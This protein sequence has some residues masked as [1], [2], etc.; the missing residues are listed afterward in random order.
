MAGEPLKTGQLDPASFK[1]NL[2]IVVSDPDIPEGPG[3]QSLRIDAGDIRPKTIEWD[4]ATSAIIPSSA[5]A[6]DFLNLTSVGTAHGHDWEVGDLAFVVNP[7]TPVLVRIPFASGG[8]RPTAITWDVD[9]DPTI[10]VDAVTGD[11]LVAI[12]TGEAHGCVWELDDVA[13]IVDKDTNALVQIKKITQLRPK[14]YVWDVAAD[15]TIPAAAINGDFLVAST[16]GTAHDYDWEINDLAFV[17]DAS[18]PV[19]QRIPKSAFTSGIATYVTSADSPV[20]AV[21]G[22]VYFIDTSTGSVEMFLPATPTGKGSIAFI[23][24]A[25]TYATN[26]LIIRRNGNPI[27]ADNT[28]DYQVA[29]NDISFEMQYAGSTYGWGVTAAR[30]AT[31]IQNAT[32][33]ASDLIEIRY[34][35]STSVTMLMGDREKLVATTSNVDGDIFLPDSTPLQPGWQATV[36]QIGDGQFTFNPA[37]GSSDVIISLSNQLVTIGKGVQ[38]S[39][40]LVQPGTWLIGGGLTVG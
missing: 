19:L 9:A 35:A 2:Q 13:Y 12:S 21:E 20:N 14:T 18:T 15:P 1:A 37:A 25:S 16:A 8:M 6:G 11:F 30:A 3:K 5:I 23:P 27:A 36:A 39:V 17:V 24:V 33:N 28:D 31:Y 40:V 29:V 22:Q 26:P 7:T 4:V 10:P 34:D 38:V 32:I